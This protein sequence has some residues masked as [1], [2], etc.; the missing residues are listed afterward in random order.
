MTELPNALNKPDDE[1]EDGKRKKEL[2]AEKKMRDP[3][4]GY[5]GIGA[6]PVNIGSGSGSGGANGKVSIFAVGLSAEPCCR[7]S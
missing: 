1:A 7:L 4:A 3:N 5:L 2:G 6:K